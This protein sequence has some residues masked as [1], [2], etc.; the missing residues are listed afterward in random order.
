MKPLIL[1]CNDDGVH[2]PGI[3]HLWQ[4]VHTHAETVVVAPSVEQS[5]TSLSITI[6]HPLHLEQINWP[7]QNAEIWSVSGTPAD[8]V[9]L[10]L[11][12]VLPRKP[13]LILSGIN[14]GSNAGRNVLYSGTIAAVIEGAINDIPGI[15]FSV[16]DFSD[17]SYCEAEPLIPLILDYVFKNPLP[18]GTFLNVNFPQKKLGKIKGMRFARQGKEYLAENP[19]RRHHPFEQMPYYW[20]GAKVASFEEDHESDIVWLR[21]GY[22]TVVPIHVGDLTHHEHFL[23]EKAAFESHVK[24]L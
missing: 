1:I 12:V 15:A 20:L 22:A 13:D 7:S 6:R 19:E 4:A 18:A 17:P 24:D 2:A 14:R 21:K 3:K 5:S 11:S 10:A 23:N 16:S 9:K 8:C